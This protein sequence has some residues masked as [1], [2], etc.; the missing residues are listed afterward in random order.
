MSAAATPTVFP[1]PAPAGVA[2]ATAVAL[3]LLLGS[4]P[5]ACRRGGGEAVETQ[6]GDL[7]V[8]ATLT[9][10]T[11]RLK[12]NTLELEVLGVNGQPIEGAEIEMVATMPA[13]GAMP[14]MRNSSEATARGDGRYRVSFDL[15][16]ST[17][18]TLALR[19]K[20]PAGEGEAR[21]SLT[22]GNEG[23]QI[24]GAGTAPAVGDAGSG[25]TASPAKTAISHYTCS[26]HP[27]VHED[28]PG[29][30][31][32]CSMDL[33]PVTTQEVASGEIVVPEGRRQRIGVRT[34]R[35]ER[36][37]MTR[38]IRTVGRVTY[39][40]AGI[41]E[42]SVKYP[43]WI[44]RLDVNTTGQPVKRGQTLFTLYSPELYAAQSEFL[45]FLRSQQAAQETAAPERADYLVRAARQRL[46]LWDLQDWQI[47]QI[48]KNGKPIRHQPIVSPVSGAVI[49][50]KIVAGAAV[51]PGMTLFRI[52]ALDRVWVEAD[53][54]ESDLPLIKVGQAARVTLPYL[55]GEAVS[56]RV[57]FI[58]PYL[59]AGT[60]TGRVR[61]ELPN[62]ELLFKPDMFAEVSFQIDSGERLV[63]PQSAVL[64]AGDRRLV[65]LDLGEG[66][67]KPQ[68]IQ[69]GPKTGDFLEVLSGLQ[70]GDLVVTSGT[71]LVAAESRLKSATEQWQ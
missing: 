22:V 14:A 43:G 4:L 11:P 33:I 19:I 41:A 46:R 6:I 56:G 3:V 17:T 42:V 64:Y 67:L 35:V 1:G 24:V 23:L 66:R 34:G 28:G 5:T 70:A 65:F 57:S 36:Q 62:R 38:E 7:T 61:I 60:R 16:M 45:T 40:E 13:M 20:S 10:E 44:E 48:A 12:G 8:R 52:A 15:G 50:K 39:D 32:I 71:F 2:R 49:E 47:D 58:L 18:W 25:A 27:S 37:R 53:L 59:D 54:P 31:P 30:C 55:P 26:M 51:E 21:Y 29:T 69:I 9:P 68:E 63:V